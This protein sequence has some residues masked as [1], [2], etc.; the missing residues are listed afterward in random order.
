MKGYD[1]ATD[2]PFDYL[3]GE[4]KE[5]DMSAEAMV[6]EGGR[7]VSP[8][9]AIPTAQEAAAID[10]EITKAIVGDDKADDDALAVGE[11]GFIAICA[12]EEKAEEGQIFTIAAKTR[13][14]L[15]KKI[16][17]LIASEAKNIG[18]L[19]IYRARRLP[20]ASQVVFKF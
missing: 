3:L 12:V 4:M 20:L 1:N 18:V 14:E 2:S 13:L 7:A 15:R 8:I 6:N 17:A 16:V 10:K 11:A 19:E 9:H 5:E